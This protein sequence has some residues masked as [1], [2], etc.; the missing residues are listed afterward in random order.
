MT[1][2]SPSAAPT[3]AFELHAGPFAGRD[4]TVVSFRGREQISAPFCFDVQVTA[5]A[6]G[7]PLAASLLGQAATLLMSVP[8][9][10][11]RVVR[12]IIA[13]VEHEG[14]PGSLGE[15]PF[16]V[17]L[18]PR[19]WL[20]KRRKRSRIF[21]DQSVAAIVDEVL[22]EYRIATRWRLSKPARPRIYCVQYQET[23]YAF[24]TRLLGEDGIF[25][26]FEHVRLAESAAST[27]EPSTWT[28]ALLLSDDANYPAL[29]DA[30]GDLALLFRD[31][32]GMVS[33]HAYAFEFALARKVRPNVALVRDFDFK[34]PAL[35]PT[36]RALAAKS[37]DEAVTAR[38]ENTVASTLSEQLEVYE[39]HSDYDQ[40]EVNE[41]RAQQVL[42]QLRRR[43]VVGR[44]ASRSRRLTPGYRFSLQEHGVDELNGAYAVTRV[45]HEGRTAEHV[46]GEVYKNTFECLPADVASRPRR[47]RHEHRQV[48]ETA[49]VV[50]PAGQEIHTDAH[51]R[52]KAQF[53]WD[54]DGQLNERS[55]CW[56]RVAQGWAGAGWGF[57]FIPRIGMEVVVTFL[58]GDT[59]RPVIT[60]CLYNSVNPPSHPLPRMATRS[61]I[62]T[63]STPD[64]NG[65]NELSFED[66][67][68][69]E[70]VYLHAQ[71]DLVEVVEN[72]HKTLVGHL[73]PAQPHGN[74]AVEVGAN[75]SLT[76]GGNR[77][78]TV[79]GDHQ[80]TIGGGRTDF[81]EQSAT[82]RVGGL[83]ERWSDDSYA[84]RI[85]GG[86]VHSVGEDLESTVGG[87][88]TLLV[89]GDHLTTVRGERLVTVEG[90]MSA[91]ARRDFA[92]IA[93]EG[94][95]LTSAESIRLVCGES[96]IE[97]LPKEIILSSP[98]VT[99]HGQKAVCAHGEGAVLHL[100]KK[101]TLTSKEVK[102]SGKDSEL[103]LTG[104]GV[105]AAAKK[106]VKLFSKGASVVLDSD[107][108]MDGSKVKLNCGGDSDGEYDEPDEIEAS[109]IDLLLTRKVPK[110][111]NPSELD[112]QGVAGARYVVEA[113]DGRKFKGALDGEGK[114]RVPI[115]KGSA[116]V[117]FP[118]YDKGRVKAK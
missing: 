60:G 106:D 99:I 113:S 51:G 100:D 29:E 82:V 16:R 47:P 79:A 54:L 85:S 94:L 11:P 105:V 8:D 57:Q 89:E 116:K 14:Q 4:L 19:L 62:R 39:H 71:R 58:G 15:V 32:E 38:T 98:T 64:S 81:V 12:G 118:D 109:F 68:G 13:S 76:V 107:A 48:A 27:S 21:Q 110:E 84:H 61:G 74:Q 104:D 9:Q 80:E 31:A 59:D 112:D 88:A 1:T 45:T 41:L 56:I 117:S 28:E 3:A 40:P 5:R 83:D 17:R 33:A 102:L 77:S 73:D 86:H 97:L 114:A 2:P 70:V 69:Q 25:F 52:V 43:T 90:S 42:E 96:V 87:S 95:T 37:R 63:R 108:S 111:G 36:E 34:N 93:G 44:G 65:S 91:S 20:L 49:T 101:A 92:V 24:V 18:V 6:E 115:P 46:G 23:D 22:A 30:G 50:G 26:C 67:R 66:Q 7:A 103:S 72:D 53:H 35:F 10:P 75:Q 78:V 55:S